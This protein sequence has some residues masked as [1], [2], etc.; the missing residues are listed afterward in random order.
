MLVI[1]PK[2]SM[3]SAFHAPLRARFP[4]QPLNY[5]CANP[6]GGPFVFDYPSKLSWNEYPLWRDARYVIAPG[7]RH[8]VS[9]NADGKVA[10]TPVDY[11]ELEPQPVL[12]LPDPYRAGYLA[13]R[14]LVSHLRELGKV[15]ESYGARA[16]VSLA[17][18]DIARALDEPLEDAYVQAMRNEG[19]LKADFDF[20]FLVN[21]AGLLTR[22][23]RAVGGDLPNPVFS[24]YTVQTLYALRNAGQPTAGE[25]VHR[26]ANWKGTG[27]YIN[28]YASLGGA[29]SRTAL[30]DSLLALGLAAPAPTRTNDCLQRLCLTPRGEAFLARLHPDCEDADLPFRLEAWMAEPET[31]RVAA[32]RYTRTWFG[33]QKRFMDR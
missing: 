4:A 8:G 2:A 3:A 24:K 13:S 11:A 20:S 31:G 32:Q 17:D 14:R 1:V 15:T 30:I 29:A 10:L 26:M 33:K 6:F 23:Y 16:V 27:K 18:P 19:Q 12:E 21:A 5:L 7:S 28:R 25:L 9:V 22:C